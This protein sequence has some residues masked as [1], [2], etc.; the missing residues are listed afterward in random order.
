MGPVAPS[1]FAIRYL[2]MSTTKNLDLTQ[3]NYEALIN[4]NIVAE[5]QQTSPSNAEIM[6]HGL[7]R[8]IAFSFDEQKTFK[9]KND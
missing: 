8:D 3:I 7:E 5:K 6:R 4:V 2:L 9:K 1:S